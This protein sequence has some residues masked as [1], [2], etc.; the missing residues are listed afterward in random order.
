MRRNLQ[1]AKALKSSGISIEISSQTTGL[2][3]EQVEN[4]N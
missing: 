1:I 4:L 2:K 3:K